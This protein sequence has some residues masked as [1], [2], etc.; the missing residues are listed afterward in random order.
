MWA[1]TAA[2]LGG[3]GGYML[4]E[5]S[6]SRGMMVG[7]WDARL[8]GGASWSLAG[9]GI[10]VLTKG[11]WYGVSYL[12]FFLGLGMLASYAASPVLARLGA[13]SFAL[14]TEGEWE[15]GSPLLADPTDP[16]WDLNT[17]YVEGE[18]MGV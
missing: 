16:E 10:G 15:M 8:F 13:A 12:F 17:D 9:L 18:T 1:G 6:E 5:I 14:N 11:R 2:G 3:I 4:G 7:N